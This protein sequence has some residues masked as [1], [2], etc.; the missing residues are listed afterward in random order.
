MILSGSETTYF[1]PKII[2][3]N[4]QTMGT[5]LNAIRTDRVAIVGLNELYYVIQNPNTSGPILPIS[6]SIHVFSLED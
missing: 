6:A 1:T 2:G 5:D 4:L 3:A